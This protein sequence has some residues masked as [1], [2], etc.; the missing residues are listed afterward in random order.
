MPNINNKSRMKY[1]KR[2]AVIIRNMSTFYHNAI[3]KQCVLPFLL[4]LIVFVSFFTA[5]TLLS[6]KYKLTDYY[7]LHGNLIY[8]NDAAFDIR[9]T[10]IFF[11]FTGIK[12]GLSSVGVSFKFFKKIAQDT[13][14]FLLQ[15]NNLKLYYQSTYCADVYYPN[16]YFDFEF[17]PI[18]DSKNG[19]FESQIGFAVV[20]GVNESIVQK[21]NPIIRVNYAYTTDNYLKETIQFLCSRLFREIRL[22]PLFVSIGVFLALANLLNWW[23]GKRFQII[24]PPKIYFTALTALFA[25]SLFLITSQNINALLFT[26]LLIFTISVILSKQNYTLLLMGLTMFLIGLL[27]FLQFNEL[28]GNNLGFWSY[29]FFLLAVFVYRKESK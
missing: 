23:P 12:N 25:F 29:F 9:R 1:F 7:Y 17:E 15:D 14:L 11:H 3:I 28:V 27:F 18:C 10:K 19:V 22:L 20:S 21:I 8:K 16:Q 4:L 5:E 13:S 6:A 24:I 26:L 2:Y